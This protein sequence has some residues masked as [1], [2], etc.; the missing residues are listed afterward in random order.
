M[1]LTKFPCALSI[2]AFAVLVAAPCASP[3]S[4]ISGDREIDRKVE[5]LL[6]QMTVE[7]KIGQLTQSFHFVNNTKSDQRVIN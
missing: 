5:A 3:Q 1:R 6:R 4:S 2:A 7:E